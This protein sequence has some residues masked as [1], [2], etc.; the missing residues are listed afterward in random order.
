MSRLLLLFM[1]Q[2]PGLLVGAVLQGIAKNL[3]VVRLQ[4]SRLL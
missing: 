2:W 4:A 1:V 3:S